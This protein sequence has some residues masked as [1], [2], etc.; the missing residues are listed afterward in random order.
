MP[1]IFA[2]V[3]R[4][5]VISTAMF[6]PQRVRW[7]EQGLIGRNARAYFP[8]GTLFSCLWTFLIA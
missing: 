6:R 2:T 4:S 8:E 7:S 5:E 1:D 3:K